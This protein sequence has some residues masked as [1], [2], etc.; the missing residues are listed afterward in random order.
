MPKQ[1]AKLE[2]F[3]GG[4]STNSDP[5]DVADNELTAA[6]DVMVDELGMIRMMGGTA[7]G[8][9]ANAAAIN[10]GYGLFQ[11]S[12]DRLEGESAG[13]SA[14]ETGD[15]Y[16]VMADT[17]GAADIDIYSRVANSWGTSKIDLGTTT[18][19]K[20]SFYAVDGALRVSD[21]NFGAANRNKWYGYIDRSKFY[22]TAASPKVYTDNSWFSLNQAPAKPTGGSFAIS[23]PG[24]PGT[25]GTAN[26]LITRVTDGEGSGWGGYAYD[27]AYS[28]V[29]DGNQESPLFISAASVDFSGWDAD[30]HPK[31]RCKLDTTQAE[32]NARI[33]Q[34]K[35]YTRK[36]VYDTEQ[37]EWTLY[38]L[39]DMHKGA[40]YG[41]LLGE[42]VYPGYSG[43]TGVSMNT[44][45]YSGDLHVKDVSDMVETY[46]S[47]TGHG[48]TDNF[49]AFGDGEGFKTSV[50]VNRVCYIGNISIVNDEGLLEVY[51]D[52][53]LKSD[54][55]KFDT[56]T[57]ERRLEASV[58]D[59]DEIVRLEEYAD[60]ILEFKKNKMSLINVS[61]EVEFLEDTF[62][63][64]GV[65]HTAAV[66]KTDFGIAWANELGCYLYD[67]QKVDNLLEK[68]GRQ[69]IKE[70]NWSSFVTSDSI[71]G[72]IPKKRQLI[73][74]KDCT[75]TSV[76]DIYLYD[77]VT[78]SWMQGDSKFTD[79]Q[80]QTNFV[81]DW[82]GDLVH[83]HTSDTGTFL[84]WDDISDATT[85]L[86]LKT[87]DI[88]FGQPSQRKKIYKAYVSYKGDGDSVTVQYA[89]NGDTDTSANFYRIN[90]DGTSSGATDS[91]TPL[92]DSDTD[93]WISAE[94]KPVG[95]INNVKSFQLQF[96]GSAES[97]FK[98]NDIS[99]VYRL[100]NVK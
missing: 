19:M 28:F 2:Q 56:F 88:D 69:I 1:V 61:Q 70:N 20:P 80:I 58:R 43:W 94:L 47:E 79:S 49:I 74:L 14:A 5:R 96:G 78:Q 71:I 40:F 77:M 51:G 11:F 48:D 60:R 63:H 90:S 82:N 52:V 16:L 17:D 36:V 31:I 25:G 6:T 26:F 22:S 93:D 81:T 87:K 53:I 65:S 92:L 97:D 33:T 83:S 59:G 89:I 18:G 100:K 46:R 44:Q 57:F 23:D 99:I 8:V 62:V 98:I 42:T 91:T 15:D 24:Y 75:A 72:Y 64:K 55:G 32:W 10:P 84:K 68:K 73:V 38:G 29:Y 3:H 9:T 34:I 67:G 95:S 54:V 30:D 85:S 76:G 35:A 50:V 41:G 39:Y 45:A 27:F 86:S 37:R 4:L 12:H 66:C 7:T 21:G 13:S